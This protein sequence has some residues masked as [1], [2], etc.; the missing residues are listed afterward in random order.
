MRF[1]LCFL[2][3]GAGLL[4][5]ADSI[6]GETLHGK[7]I[8]G[9]SK[10]PAVNTADHRLVGLDGDVDTLRI[11]HDPRLNGVEVEAKGHFTA[12]DRFTIDPIH[13]RALMARRDGKLKLISYFCDVCNIRANTPGPCV[14]CQRETTLEL[15]DPPRN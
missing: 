2:A 11:L 13:T 4:W 1:C 15:I 14:C 6:P 9:E 10:P 3:L 8:V 7:L 12:P 5:A